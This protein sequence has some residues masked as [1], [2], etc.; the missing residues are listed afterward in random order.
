MYSYHRSLWICFTIAA[1]ILS[2]A[3]RPS[4]KAGFSINP[5]YKPVKVDSSPKPLNIS[6]IRAQIPYLESADSRG[7]RGEVNLKVF[8]DAN[9]NYAG[10]QVIGH[11]HPLLKLPCEAYVRML[12]F[13]PATYN[14]RKVSG[15]FI[16]RHSFGM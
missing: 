11:S 6:Q 9:G 10:H 5:E 15:T 1:L 12:R 8:V 14:G 13:R 7:I 4:D 3:F 2:V 16:F